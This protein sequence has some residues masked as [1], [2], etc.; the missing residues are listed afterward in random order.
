MTATESDIADRVRRLREI[1]GDLTMVSIAPPFVTELKNRTKDT[2]PRFGP[3]RTWQRQ[4]KTR[5]WHITV[6]G[7]FGD[8]SA[9]LCTAF[10]DEHK[11]DVGQ[12]R[13]G[14]VGRKTWKATWD[15]ATTEGPEFPGVLAES[16]TVDENVKLW[17]QQL[18]NR[19]WDI[20]ADGIFQ[21]ETKEVCM[22]FQ[23]EH[24][25]RVTGKI[26]QK[27]WDLAWHEHALNG[28]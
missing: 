22:N 27:T 24:F 7:D 19:G 5:G 3:V 23:A 13:N 9:Q 4:M 11:D 10:Q 20:G 28:V 15:A 2:V 26:D 12:E 14:V 6:D 21:D 1:E 17:Q 16:P 25:L 8:V 18:K